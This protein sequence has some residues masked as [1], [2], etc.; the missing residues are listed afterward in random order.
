LKIGYLKRTR[1]VL[2]TQFN[3][4]KATTYT[5]KPWKKFT[6]IE[7]AITTPQMY[8]RQRNTKQRK[9]KLINRLGRNN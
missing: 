5:A 7:K 1:Q 3:N 4:K 9:S 2:S 6:A 8:R